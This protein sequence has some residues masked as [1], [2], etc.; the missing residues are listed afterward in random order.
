MKVLIHKKKFNNNNNNNNLIPS[1][2][3]VFKVG[4]NYALV[5]HQAEAIILLN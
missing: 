4:F 5:K 2:G 3:V 1:M